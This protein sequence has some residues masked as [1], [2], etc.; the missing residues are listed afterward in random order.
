MKAH[1]SHQICWNIFYVYL[2]THAWQGE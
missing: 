2:D 1:C